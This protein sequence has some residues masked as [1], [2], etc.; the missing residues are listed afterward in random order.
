MHL[1]G[2]FLY[3]GFLSELTMRIPHKT[4]NSELPEFLSEMMS[5]HTIFFALSGVQMRQYLSIILVVFLPCN[6]R[7]ASHQQVL[8]SA[9]L[10]KTLIVL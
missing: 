9:P 5:S 8:G 7:K 10:H 1:V 2:V 3:K 4:T 6:H